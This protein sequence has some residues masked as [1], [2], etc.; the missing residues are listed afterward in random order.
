MR[1]HVT[2]SR[3]RHQQIRELRVHLLCQDDLARIV[4]SNIL[5][6]VLPNPVMINYATCVQGVALPRRLPPT[7]LI[8]E[9]FTKLTR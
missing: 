8:H 7:R 2:A 4:H 3:S 9:L 6:D 5:L 1:G